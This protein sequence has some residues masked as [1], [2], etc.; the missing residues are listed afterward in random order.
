M[1]IITYKLHEELIGKKFAIASPLILSTTYLW[2]DYSHL[3]TQDLIYSCL[4]TIGIFSIVKI[5][6]KK[7]LGYIF[8]FGL[9]I[10][11]AFM[12]KTFLVAIPITSLLP[13]LIKKK[14]IVTSK[15][16]WIGLIIGFS[17]FILWTTSINAFLDKNIIFHL[18]DKFNL[19]LIHI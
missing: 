10:G 18:L 9:W 15:Y 5:N 17:P 14:Y 8:L 6:S 16:F 13:C 2:F 11:L 3:A 1:L 4:V 19:S 12:M 7:E